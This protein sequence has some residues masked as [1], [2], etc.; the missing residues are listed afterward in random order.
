[1][2]PLRFPNSGIRAKRG[3]RVVGDGQ[4]LYN[5]G[6]LRPG[7]LQGRLATA[8]PPA[9]WWPAAAKASLQG[10][11]DASGLQVAA[12]RGSSPQWRHLR[13]EASP[14]RATACHQQGQ[15]SPVTGPQRSGACGGATRGS[16]AD[17]RGG[18][19]WAR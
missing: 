13:A 8:W 17:Y 7:P 11:T 10:A 18:C 12:H 3:R 4:A 1:M 16:E 19:R 6:W 14:V 5:G 9:R 15:R 2:H